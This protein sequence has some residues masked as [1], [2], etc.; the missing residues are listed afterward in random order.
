MCQQK[1]E[2]MIRSM[3]GYG[4]AVALIDDKKYTVEIRSVNGKT[5]DISLKTSQIPREKEPELRQQMAARLQRGNIDMFITV[6]QDENAVPDAFNANLIAHYYNELKHIFDAMHQEVAPADIAA[7]LLRMPEVRETRKAEM[8]PATWESLNKCIGEAMESLDQFRAKEGERL[9][10][11]LLL[12]VDLIEQDLTFVEELDPERIA[13][14]RSK[15]KDRLNGLGGEIPFDP[16][17]L[18]QELIY[19]LEK[20]D[21]TEERVRLRQHCTYFRQTLDNEPYPGRKLNFI[22]QEMGREINTLGSK[23]TH[24]VMQQYVVKMKDE[25]EKIKEQVLNVL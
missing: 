22:A 8:G 17:R 21:I 24:A 3:T 1:F 25:L 9:G 7:V 5:A 4:K 6:E 13:L 10:K 18:E 23:A 11:D 14:V 15:L 2:K 16:N 12:R 20:A 19:Y